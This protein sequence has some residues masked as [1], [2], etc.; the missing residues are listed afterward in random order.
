M[1]EKG[2]ASYLNSS[3][4]NYYALFN[5]TFIYIYL[6]MEEEILRKRKLFYASTSP[7]S[8]C[9]LIQSRCSLDTD[10]GWCETGLRCGSRKSR[11]WVGGELGSGSLM[12]FVAWPFL[13]QLDSQLLVKGPWMWG[14]GGCSHKGVC[15]KGEVTG[16]R[17]WVSSVWGHCK[18]EG[19][20]L[21]SLRE[22][23]SGEFAASRWVPGMHVYM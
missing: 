11:L 15:W 3:W 12:H 9:S 6:L 20:V 7:S 2:Q 21:P 16:V 23:P 18:R 14:V 13:P 10:Q 8:S 1:A 17:G 5:F 19:E 4:R 22:Q